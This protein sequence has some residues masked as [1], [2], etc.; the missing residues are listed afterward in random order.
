MSTIET[1]VTTIST[2]HAQTAQERM[3]ELQRWREQIPHFVVPPTPDATR[4]LS[5][6]AA[7]PAEFLHLTA[8]SLAN[9]AALARTDGIPPA[10]MRDLVSYADAYGPLADEL[11]AL[12]QFLRH[13]V[14]SA[15]NKAGHEAMLTY[16]I[17]QRLAKLPET[18]HLAPHVADMRRA[19]A[20]GRKTSPEVL[21]KRAAARKAKAAA[22]ADEVPDPVTGS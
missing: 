1:E 5:R 12:A 22:K 13:S 9:Q 19:L 21:A 4:R 18:A 6:T 17:A 14:T 15:R 2:N 3:L 8:L 10:E 11:E 16:T 20:A 7:I